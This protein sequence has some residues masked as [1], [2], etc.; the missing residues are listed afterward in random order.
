MKDID[1]SMAEIMGWEKRQAYFCPYNTYFWFDGDERQMIA[2][3]WLPSIKIAQAFQVVEKITNDTLWFQITAVHGRGY[4]VTIFK[5]R[6]GKKTI[7]SLENE[8][9]TKF[10][11]TVSLAICKAVL[12]TMEA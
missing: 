8:L 7:H 2:N 12:K 4:E 1:D 10:E 11:S 6:L 9:V 5:A 3:A